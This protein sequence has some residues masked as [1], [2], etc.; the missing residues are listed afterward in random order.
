MH[1]KI[2]WILHFTSDRSCSTLYHCSRKSI[3]YIMIYYPF[4]NS[5][6]QEKNYHDADDKRTH[7]NA[8]GSKS[9]FRQL[10]GQNLDLPI[11]KGTP[12]Q[13]HLGSQPNVNHCNALTLQQDSSI[14]FFSSKLS[15]GSFYSSLQVSI[16]IDFF[17]NLHVLFMD[18][19]KALRSD[20]WHSRHP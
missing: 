2:N 20:L 16:F 17:H 14:S 15:S 18:L 10:K 7:G 3:S 6:L 5:E 13:Q 11:S 9:I 1:Q 19:M 4:L 12:L 8:C